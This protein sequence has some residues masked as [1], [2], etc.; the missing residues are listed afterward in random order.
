MASHPAALWEE[1]QE[2][3]QRV[4]ACPGHCSPS[5]CLPLGQCQALCVLLALQG[6]PPHQQRG[7]GNSLTCQAALYPRLGARLQEEILGTVPSSQGTLC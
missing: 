7:A 2:Q 6:V 3:S 4:C 5:I 1:E